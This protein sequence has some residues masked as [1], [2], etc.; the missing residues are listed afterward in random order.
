[1][2]LTLPDSIVGTPLKMLCFYD[3]DINSGKVK[4]A[5]WQ[6]ELLNYL[7]K[8]HAFKDPAVQAIL[9][10]ANGSG[11]SQFILAPFA[12]WMIMKWQESLTIITTASGNQ[13]DAQNLR[14]CT[15]LAR[16]INEFHK[17]DF[18]EQI[19][20]CQYRKFFNKVTESYLNM[21]ATDET[22][23]AEGWHP[24][25]PDGKFAI[26]VDEGK[27]VADDIYDALERCTGYT[28]RLEISSAGKSSGRFYSMWHNK[29]IEDVV[30]KK[31]IT[32]FMC[33]HIPVE[34]INQKIKKYGLH[35]PLIRSSIYSEFTSTDQQVVI[36][37]ELLLKS[38]SLCS[39]HYI[40]GPLRAGFDL[41][42]GGDENS[43][44]VW[45]GNKEIS[46]YHCKYG[47]TS[48]TVR[49]YIDFIQSFKGQ[50]KAE[51]VY[52]DDGGVGRGILDNF[53][54]KGYK[55]QRI[56]NQSRPFDNTRYSNRGTELWWNFRRFIEE[57]QVLFLKNEKGDLDNTLL[58]Q[59]SNRYYKTQTGT[60]KI[61]LEAKQLAKKE[62]HPSPDRADAIILAWSP[63]IYP[64]EEISGASKVKERRGKTPEEV[65]R[66]IMDGNY[67][68]FQ[69]N[70]RQPSLATKLTTKNIQLQGSNYSHKNIFSRQNQKTKSAYFRN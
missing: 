63:Y 37:R 24:I 52:A 64:L 36:T 10:A 54:E 57:Y 69:V 8:P 23:K 7:G 39:E 35:D 65:Y 11:K 2:A 48:K 33:P 42:A 38:A 3:D 51:N 34:E 61:I 16:K 32:A 30:L 28:H 66:E 47:D 18:P 1:M 17:A 46:A 60:G 58:N 5:G 19:I 56:L 40:F 29:E 12:I 53:R 44:S 9:L 50:L 62:G 49:E 55:F 13:L 59:L 6:I 14:Y 27:T 22:G 26:I 4:L 31:R 45:L 41:A 43:M 15:R 21:F 70:A 20:D 68:Q 25:K 67:A